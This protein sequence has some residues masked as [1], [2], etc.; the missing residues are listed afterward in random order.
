MSEAIAGLSR[1]SLRDV[2][3]NDEI[4]IMYRHKT[5]LGVVK[6]WADSG[7]KID[8]DAIRAGLDRRERYFVPQYVMKVNTPRYHTKQECE[9]LRARFE[10]FETP[11]EIEQLG[12]DKLSE[13]QEFCEREW[14]QY[15]DKPIDIF[16]A[17]VGSQFRVSISP[18]EV[19]YNSQEG[20]ESVQDR[21]EA[22]LLEEVHREADGLREYAKS[23]GLGGYLY[24]PPK[25]LYSLTKDPALDV[26]RKQGFIEL[27]KFKK[28]I[29][30][31]VFNFHHIELK[32]PEG[33]LSDELLAALGFLP[34]KACCSAR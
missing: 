3:N 26:A 21:S 25:Q 9:F 31:L 28:A 10:N 33:L 8:A 16:W 14:P 29:K 17:H 27:L 20:P 11:P 30:M 18:K 22:E 19:S 4:V 23:N 12:P 2:L 32:M 7:V 34:C 5:T 6:Q 1:F 13:F 15:K 24:A